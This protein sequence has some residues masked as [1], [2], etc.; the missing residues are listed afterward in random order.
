M[1]HVALAGRD[2]LGGPA[3]RD[4]PAPSMVRG[5]LTALCPV[6]RVDDCGQENANRARDK[7]YDV[8]RVHRMAHGDPDRVCGP[9]RNGKPRGLSWAGIGTSH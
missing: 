5:Q 2:I 9:N 8:V 6:M 3:H 1:D 7:P 4:Y